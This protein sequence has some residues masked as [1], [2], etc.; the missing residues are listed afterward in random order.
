[1]FYLV[2]VLIGRAVA[3]L[4]RT[5]TYYTEDE[6]IHLGMRVLVSFGPSKSTIGFVM[7]EPEPVEEDIKEYLKTN[8][9]K[10]SPIQKTID[11]APLLNDDLIYLAKRISDYYK[12]DL[13]KIL[14]TMLPPSLKPKDSALKKSQGKTVDFIFALPYDS[15]LLSKNELS[16]YELIKATKNGIQKSK[17]TAK[18]S[19]KK[20]LDKKAVE[21]KP[22]PV[23]RIPE[24][25]AETLIPFDLTKE[26]EDAYNSVLN[27]D[28]KVYLLQGV[29]G[30]GKTEVYIHLAETMLK[31]GKGVLILVP[32][33]AL[34]D[35][36][37]YLFQCHFKDTISILNSS[38]SDSRKYDEYKKI[39]EGQS[40]IVLGTRSAV[41]APIK[42]LSL[43]IIDEEHSSSYKQDT[44]PYYDAI[45]VAMMRSEKENCKVLLASATP[46]VIDKARAEKGIYH[47]LFMNQRIAKNQEKEIIMVNMNNP[48]TLD[49][50]L[51]SMF[52]KRLIHELEINLK[53]NE[54]SMIL[55]NRRGYSPIYICRHCHHTA[56]CPNCQIPMN[57]HKKDDSLRCHHCG[58]KVSTIGYHCE[59][60]STDFQ[61]LGFGTERAYEELRSFF[62]MAKITRMDSDISSNEI[63]HQVLQ[64]FADGETDIIV[65]TEIIAKGHDFPRVSLAAILDADSSLRIPSYLANEETFDLISQFVGRAGRKDLKGR[66]VLQSYNPE[67]QVIKLAAKQDYNTFY[68]LEMEERKK[69]QYPPYTYLS[70]INIKGVDIHEVINMADI[71]K[72][73]L[74]KEIDGL[75][76]NVYGPSA[77]YIPH[78]NGRY[79]R[80]ILLKYKSLDEASKVLDSIKLLR[81]ENDKVEISINVDIGK[82]NN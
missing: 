80:T 20:L 46:R 26:Q 72:N 16:L 60:S 23:S 30:S 54:Q 21:V 35:H 50:S 53:S 43:I 67:N 4:D 79:Y 57:Y 69:Y 55:I 48:E 42:N 19:L 45:T 41:F 32:E 31:Q 5:F 24:I 33:I 8:K 56:L 27:C 2:K 62:P 11:Q 71:V 15:K 66:I 49:P 39:L 47:P 18:A 12:A 3:S 14:Q 40:K 29:T 51:S 44:T 74:L 63:R 38:L 75:R 36:M 7:E 25:I 1:M 22:V 68:K 10:L 34:T 9:I 17:I 59:C 76:F 37:L 28:D 81:L 64:D 73:H 13:I 70:A 65:G 52:S 6:N 61:A 77:P 82:E 58:Y 78:I